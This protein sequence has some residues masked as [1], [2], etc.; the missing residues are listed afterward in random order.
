MPIYY[1]KSADGS[2]MKEFEGLYVNPN[3]PSEWSNKRYH[4]KILNSKERVIKYMNGRLCLKDVYNQIINKVCLLSKRD[5]D[6]VLS[7]YNER[8]EFKNEED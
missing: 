8:G 2:D 7:H 4:D 1:G 5:R 3:N 6:F